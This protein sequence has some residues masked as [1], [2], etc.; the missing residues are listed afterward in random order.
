MAIFKKKYIEGDTNNDKKLNELVDSDGSFIGGDRNVTGDSEIE[1]GPVQKPF[2]DNSDYEKGISTTTDRAVRYR[3]DIPWFATYSTGG[4]VH[5]VTESKKIITKKQIDELV[6]N[7][8]KKSDDIDI[9]DKS[10]NKDLKK[11]IN[12]INNSDFNDDQ[13]NKIKKVLDDLKKSN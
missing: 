8:V 6:E 9:I 12:I 3:Q 10:E 7:L 5:R 13:R 1:T 4:A 2:N 11:I